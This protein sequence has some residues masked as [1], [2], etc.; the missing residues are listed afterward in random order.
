MQGCVQKIWLDGKEHLWNVTEGC[1]FVDLKM[2]LS[3]E[4]ADP[5]SHV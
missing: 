3:R 5:Y 1:R 4:E 2:V